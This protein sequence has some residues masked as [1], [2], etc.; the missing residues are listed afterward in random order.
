MAQWIQHM[1]ILI[2]EII[3]SNGLLRGMFCWGQKHNEIVPYNSFGNI[4]FLVNSWEDS[5][6]W[7]PK[8]LYSTHIVWFYRYGLLVFRCPGCF[9]SVSK[10]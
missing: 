2:L 1:L 5:Y 8:I 10:Y 7:F 9:V 4:H 3:Y 6:K